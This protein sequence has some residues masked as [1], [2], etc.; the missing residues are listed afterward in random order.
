MHEKR[1]LNL[2]KDE[3]DSARNAAMLFRNKEALKRAEEEQSDYKKAAVSLQNENIFL[4]CIKFYI[5]LFTIQPLHLK[6]K[7]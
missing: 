4:V 6:I 1:I 7:F 5:Y 3:A 2:R